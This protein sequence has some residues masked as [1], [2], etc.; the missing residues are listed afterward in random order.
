MLLLVEV[1][2][3]KQL[4][5]SNHFEFFTNF[6]N[7]LFLHLGT[8]CGVRGRLTLE[9]ALSGISVIFCQGVI[10]LAGNGLIIFGET[11]KRF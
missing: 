7:R 10:E 3:C 5:L 2:E 6:S 1:Y 11:T 9:F 8:R 4:L